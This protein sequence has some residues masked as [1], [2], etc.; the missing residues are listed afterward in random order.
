[1]NDV[2]RRCFRG[3]APA[4]GLAAVLMATAVPGHASPVLALV[5]GPA[6]ANPYQRGPD[7]TDASITAETGPFK[8]ASVV[9]PSNTDPG[10]AGGTIYYPTDT[11]QGTFAPIV[12]TP[13]FVSPQWA[14]SWYGPRLA[15]QGFVV[16]TI[17]TLGLFD[18]VDQRGKEML[19]A[20]DY[21]TNRSAVKDRIDPTRPGLMGHSMGGG[22]V[23]RA[24]AERPGIKA[25]VP[26]APWDPNSSYAWNVKAD[27]LVVGGESDMIA[28]VAANAEPIYKDL[29]SAPEKAYL[30]LSGADHVFAFNLPNTTI[31]KYAIAW[32]K[33]FL[34]D[35]VRYDRFLCP[36]PAPGGAI[37]QYQDT[38]PN[39]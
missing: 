37:K 39:G 3:L 8:T 34:D 22:G 38:C 14:I 19:A 36:A 27:T 26:L 28:P 25:V 33:R 32:M 15:S 17:D 18:V 6:L 21:L 29:R 10:F 7:P 9:V 35:D 4:V 24:A 11:S 31:A 5:A 1:M 30:E 20:L 13:G 12:V 16:M 23:I 2:T